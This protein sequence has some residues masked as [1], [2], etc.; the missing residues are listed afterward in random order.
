[1]NADFILVKLCQLP[2]NLSEEDGP[3][4]R[5]TWLGGRMLEN[6]HR[7]VVRGATPVLS[8]LFSCKVL[9]MVNS[10]QRRTDRVNLRPSGVGEGNN[11]CESAGA[12]P[13]SQGRCPELISECKA[14]PTY[15]TR[16]NS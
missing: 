14:A 7:W 11:G 15:A 8:L 12:T 6:G 10:Q 3:R 4:R 5:Q 2:E 1:M 13:G 16:T 9:F